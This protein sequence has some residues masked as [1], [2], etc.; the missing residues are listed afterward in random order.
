M[1]TVFQ[2]LQDYG[3]AVYVILFLYC[4]LKS[5]ALPLFGGYAAQQG[6]GS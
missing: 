5:G 6:G 1:E 3:A 4:V 2:L